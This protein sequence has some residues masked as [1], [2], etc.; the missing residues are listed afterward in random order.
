MKKQKENNESI[1]QQLEAKLREWMESGRSCL[2]CANQSVCE[3]VRLFPRICDTLGGVE[4]P[5][6]CVKSMIVNLHSGAMK[7]GYARLMAHACSWY[8]RDKY[9][10]RGDKRR[11]T[12]DE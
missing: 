5:L 4:E 1:D 8:R 3:V 6:Y 7:L 10:I 11:V 12:D 2:T 9:P